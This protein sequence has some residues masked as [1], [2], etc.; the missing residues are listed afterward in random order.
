MCKK[1]ICKPG[2]LACVRAS[3]LGIGLA[4]CSAD[5]TAWNSV[6]LLCT[7]PAL[8]G[9]KDC[10]QCLSNGEFLNCTGAPLHVD[11]FTLASPCGALEVCIDQKGC[12]EQVCAP[13]DL[14]CD[15]FGGLERCDSA[16]AEWEL[17]SPSCGE[18]PCVHCVGDGERVTCT[19][20]SKLGSQQTCPPGQGCVPTVG[21]AAYDCTSSATHCDEG[22]SFVKCGD[23]GFGELPLS[24]G[25]YGDCADGASGFGCGCGDGPGCQ[26]LSGCVP[27]VGT[28]VGSGGTPELR[29][30]FQGGVSVSTG[31]RFVHIAPV[32]D[33]STGLPIDGLAPAAPGQPGVSLTEDGVA[34]P[35]TCEHLLLSPDAALDLVFVL[36]VTS[37]MGA[38]LDALRDNL[39]ALAVALGQSGLDVRFGAVGFGD[40][41][42]LASVAPLPLTEELQTFGEVLKTWQVVNGG[43]APES[44]L[45]ALAYSHGAMTWRPG[46]Q[47]ALVLITDA[48]LHDAFDGSGASTASLVSVLDTLA[49]QASVHVIGPGEGRPA[50]EQARWPTAALVGCASG[51]SRQALA[52][53][54]THPVEYSPLVRGLSQSLFCTYESADPS[55]AH[56]LTV[57]VRAEVAGETLEGSRTR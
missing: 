42:P 47:R 12:V 9:P 6:K 44:G 56:T 21:C 11:A 41:A 34:R 39:L 25:A 38:A 5:G 19:A 7:H 50:F 16:G 32:V 36:D 15:A 28:G 8:G 14:R 17:D 18:F 23:D 26:A 10:F 35:L 20:P 4:A 48:P 46:A 1:S 54:M 24:C 33:P 49:G 2:T 57:T 22:G 43:D 31:K 53:F 52:E 37:S 27:E 3:F 55:A 30:I 51:G 45:D 40:T 13:G 29:V